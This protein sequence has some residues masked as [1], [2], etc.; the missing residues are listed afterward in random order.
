MESSTST[1]TNDI[2]DSTKNVNPIQSG[3][4]ECA[5]STSTSPVF[6][7]EF[8]STGR[9]GRRNALGDILD[10]KTAYITT[11]GL[12]DQLEAMS[13]GAGKLICF[14]LILQ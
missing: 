9:T 6:V 10:E 4:M 2:D 8:L 13:F 11:A 7:Q 1:P 12:S 3:T 5:P 14:Q